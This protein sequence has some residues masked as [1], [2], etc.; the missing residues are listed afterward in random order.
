M[1]TGFYEGHDI[2]TCPDG[3][4]L[5]SDDEGTFCMVD[6]DR[7]PAVVI[8]GAVT[9]KPAAK[10]KKAPEGKQDGNG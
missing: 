5:R 7:V 4:K 6:G 2:L 9:L 1:S 10:S 3:D 8:N